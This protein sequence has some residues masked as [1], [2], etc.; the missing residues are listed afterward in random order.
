MVDQKISEINASRIKDRMRQ[1]QQKRVLLQ[2]LVLSFTP[3]FFWGLYSVFFVA[4][5]I[6]FFTAQRNTV[7]IGSLVWHIRRA[8]ERLPVLVITRF[9]PYAAPAPPKK[10]SSFADPYRNWRISQNSL[11][12]QF[13]SFLFHSLC[14]RGAVRA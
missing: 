5:C 8:A 6:R 9:Y 1:K 12:L 2:L 11:F 14:A 7:F 13:L 4:K 3:G 10:F